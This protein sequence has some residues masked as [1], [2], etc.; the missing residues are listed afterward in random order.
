VKLSAG[1]KEQATKRGSK[2]LRVINLTD[3][4]LDPQPPP[5]K[6]LCTA[7]QKELPLT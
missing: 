5:F 1:Q 3:D 4:F 7:Q 6:R 2:R